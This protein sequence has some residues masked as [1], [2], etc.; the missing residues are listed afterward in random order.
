MRSLDARVISCVIT[1]PTTTS[2]AKD[3]CRNRGSSM[4]QSLVS[5]ANQDYRWEQL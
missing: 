5:V 2:A 3:G 4:G 1:L